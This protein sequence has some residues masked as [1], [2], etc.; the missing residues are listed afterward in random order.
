[1]NRAHRALLALNLVLLACL[2]VLWALD[3]SLE[4]RRKAARSADSAFHSLADAGTPAVASVA[5]VDLTLPGSG[6]KWMYVRREESW[7]L[8]QYRDGFGMGQEIEGLLKAFL[9]GHG[10]VV[11]RMTSGAEH[12]GIVRGRTL[13]A[14]LYDAGSTLILHALAGSVAPGQ[15][16]GECFAAAEGIDRVLHMDSNPWP[17]VQWTAESRFPPLLDTKVTPVA[18]R[19]G[20]PAKL[21]FGGESPPA[22]R[23]VIRR[24]VPKEQRMALGPDRGPRYEWYGTAA[25]GEQ[26]LND[27]AAFGYAGYLSSLAFDELLGLKTGREALFERPPLTVTIEYDGNV[28]DTLILGAAGQGGSFHLLHSTTGQVFLVS[29]EKAK[30]L[31]PDVRALLEPPRQPPPRQP[32]PAL[33]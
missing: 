3:A 19:R 17:Y 20:L 14:D 13:E 8:P 28:K 24:E 31:T 4:A 10:T 26:R 15:R 32:A 25:G 33:K 16:S 6:T 27:N 22:I 5:R 29:P 23:E 21:I 12:F 7:R 1:M 2:G 9:E 11:G 18:L 30:G